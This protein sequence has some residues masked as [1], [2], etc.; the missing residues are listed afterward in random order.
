MIS[1]IAVVHGVIEL[2]GRSKNLARVAAA[3]EGARLYS[4]IGLVV[5][6]QM[7]NGATLYKFGGEQWEAK[8]KGES[9]H[10]RTIK[11]FVDVASKHHVNFLL[12]PILERRGARLYRSAIFMSPT[13]VVKA[14][15]QTT[16]PSLLGQGKELPLIDAE[17]F[18]LWI[19]MGEDIFYPEL[20]FVLCLSGAQL[21]VFYPSYD[22][23]SEKQL[24]LASARAIEAGL[25]VLVVGGTVIRRG[26]TLASVPTTVINW[27]GEVEEEVRE[28]ETKLVVVTVNLKERSAP[29]NASIIKLRER[30]LR[31]ALGSLLS[32]FTA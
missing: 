7:L 22:L 26:R 10:G 24:K 6:P 28:A 18:R 9:L 29:I 31:R 23:D 13:G 27:R 11:F 32:D 12:G 25:P 15:R 16:M 20:A 21:V 1:R 14:V 30:A 19:Y 8:I 3:I 2:G 4:G 5:L 17:K